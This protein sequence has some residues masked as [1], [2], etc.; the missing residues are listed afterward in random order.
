MPSFWSWLESMRDLCAAA[1]SRTCYAED[2]LRSLRW[3][4]SHCH[5]PFSSSSSFSGD[6][7]R[8][9]QNSW[10]M[11]P[12]TYSWSCICHT[13]SQ[14]FAFWAQPSIWLFLPKW[15]QRWCF[16][17]LA[18][19]AQDG[20]FGVSVVASTITIWCHSFFWVAT[21]WLNQL[22]SSFVLCFDLCNYWGL[23]APSS[24]PIY[25]SKWTYLLI[26]LFLNLNF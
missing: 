9:L 8:H 25:S 5:V 11:K 18:L 23:S 20:G 14:T 2:C 3:L 13:S 19:R 16:F 10:W 26:I 1:E 22:Q 7:Q 6:R 15:D 4:K 24:C 21:R 17:D 12:L